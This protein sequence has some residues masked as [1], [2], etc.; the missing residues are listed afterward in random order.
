V[1]EAAGGDGRAEALD[2]GLVADELV[3]GLRERHVF[4]VILFGCEGAPPSPSPRVLFGLKCSESFGWGWTCGGHTSFK[5]VRVKVFSRL[6][7]QVRC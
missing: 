4:Q 5:G 6:G 3:E 1:R 2:R 7:L